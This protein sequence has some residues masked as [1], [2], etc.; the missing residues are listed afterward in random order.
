[1]EI[2]WEIAKVC[3]KK[4]LSAATATGSIANNGTLVPDVGLF[5]FSK[6]YFLKTIDFGTFL[7]FWT[8]TWYFLAK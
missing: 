1:M 4:I 7:K 2:K 6:Y 5:A 3:Q 8:F